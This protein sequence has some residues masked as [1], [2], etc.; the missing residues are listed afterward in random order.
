MVPPTFVQ[1]M[2][3]LSHIPVYFDIKLTRFDG[4]ASQTLNRESIKT[5]DDHV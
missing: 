2:L 1:V 4:L 3:E 5:A